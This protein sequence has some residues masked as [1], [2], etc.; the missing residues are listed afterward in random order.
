MNTVK[1]IGGKKAERYGV[2][3]ENKMLVRKR[4][5]ENGHSKI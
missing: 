2:I 4:S 1:A 5:G 3:N